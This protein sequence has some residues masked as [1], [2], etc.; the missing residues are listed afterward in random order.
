MRSEWTIAAVLFLFYGVVL[1]IIVPRSHGG[2]GFADVDRKIAQRSVAAGSPLK[3]NPAYAKATG[4]D[5]QFYYYIALDPV[6]A[7]PYIDDPSYRYGRIVY[8]LAARVLALGQPTLIPYTLILI[9]GL[10]VV[11]GTLAIGALLRR[12]GASPWIALVYGLYPGLVFALRHDLTEPLAFAFVALALYLF[13]LRTR[14]ALGW[15]GVSFALATLTRES[16]A[17]FGITYAAATFLNGVTRGSVASALVANWRRAAV[18]VAFTL[19]PFGLYKLFLLHWVGA[20]GVPSTVAPT[21]VPFSGIFAYWPWHRIA[22]EQVAFV[23]VPGLI[24][25]VAALWA[26]WKRAWDVEVWSLLVNVLLF[27]VFLNVSSYGNT[28]SSLRV[29]SGVV[30]AAL[31]CLPVVDRVTG[32]NRWWFWASAALWLALLPFILAAVSPFK[33]LHDVTSGVLHL[34]RHLLHHS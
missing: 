12:C 23:T 16:S 4:Y 26:L 29:T 11:G 30:L 5:G 31:L 1:T 28:D 17:V 9:N 10:A 14:R 19:A 7:R 6:H 21:L 2:L 27:V 32:R 18:L 33:T 34:A 3:L 15:A 22:L 25:G 24:C 8:P 20:S 13:D